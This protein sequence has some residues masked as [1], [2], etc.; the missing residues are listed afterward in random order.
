MLQGDED[1]SMSG[2]E[3]HRA[4]ERRGRV[5]VVDDEDLVRIVLSRKL[6]L[7]G[8]EVLLA[9]DGL[10]A[11]EVAQLAIPDVVLTDLNMPRCNG[12]RLCM[13]LKARPAMAGI[14]VVIMTG[15][16]TDEARMQAAGCAAVLYKPL[17]DDLPEL[18]AALLE[19]R[20]TH[21]HEAGVMGPSA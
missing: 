19:E 1:S 6:E 12:E 4:A 20:A 14:P 11:L 16:P 18:L 13:D 3:R 8:F 2:T 17:P 15:G 10:E 21:P 9:R 7:H 5:L